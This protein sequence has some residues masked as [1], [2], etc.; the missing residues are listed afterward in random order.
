MDAGLNLQTEVPRGRMAEFEIDTG[1]MTRQAMRSL[2]WR[3]RLTRG[4]LLVERVAR[5]FWPLIALSLI[6]I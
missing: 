1:K 2:K 5:S 4:S 3:L 6:H